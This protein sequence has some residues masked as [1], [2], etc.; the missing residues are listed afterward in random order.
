MGIVGVVMLGTALAVAIIGSGVV[1]DE[2]L[3]DAVIQTFDFRPGAIIDR[4]DL[5]RPI[6]EPLSAY[7]HFGRTD[8]EVPWEETDRIED[9]KKLCV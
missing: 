6:Y 1:S 3:R 2:R 9:L 5:L 7:G 4:F 8:V